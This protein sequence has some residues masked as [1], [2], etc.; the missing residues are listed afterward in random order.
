[1]S[2]RHII[3]ALR[4]SRLTVFFL[5]LQT[6]LACA[7]ICNAL[8]FI[9]HQAAPVLAST[10]IA[11]AQ[12]LI[13]D[14]IQSPFTYDTKTH[15]MSGGLKLADLRALEERIR[16]LPGVK[17]VSLDMGVPYSGSFFGAMD[18]HAEHSAVLTPMS[19]YQGDHLLNAL[20][21]ELVKGRDFRPNEIITMRVAKKSAQPAVAIITEYV[22]HRLFPDGHALGERLFTGTQPEQPGPIV[23]GI[24]RHMPAYQS[25]I[26]SNLNAAVI[27][28]EVNDGLPGVTLIVRTAPSARRQV[29]RKLPA[30][31][32]HNL[33]LSPASYPRVRAFEAIHDEYFQPNR[34]KIWL[35]LGV[36]LAVIA[37]T[38]IGIMGLTGFWVQRRTRVVGIRRALGATRGD[39][40]RYF[41]VE[42]LLIVGTGIVLGVPAAYGGNLWLMT[43]LELARLPWEWLLIGAGVLFV[44]GQAAALVPARRAAAVPP[45]VATRSV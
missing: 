44:L 11:P 13:V 43:H 7:F 25:A 10:G 38:M 32:G 30:V 45:V 36:T 8:F 2:I 39:I 26:T 23:V 1:M 35:M 34:S 40:L 27:L 42:N 16:A 12:V 31:I 22:A 37:I 33:E 3:S 15:A 5:I 9:A 17:A 28:P 41:M 6:V 18:Y 4:F 21:L 14:Q 29:A 24:V 19:L 20:G